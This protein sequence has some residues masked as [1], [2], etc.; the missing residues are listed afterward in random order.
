MYHYKGCTS[1][2]PWLFSQQ[3]IK[4]TCF[5]SLHVQLVPCYTPVRLEHSLA[6]SG[7]TNRLPGSTILSWA[8]EYPMLGPSRDFNTKRGDFKILVLFVVICCW[9]R[10]FLENQGSIVACKTHENQP[11]AIKKSAGSLNLTQI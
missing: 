11:F 7:G 6:P 9:N 1:I 8:L 5:D 10:L 2:Y 4:K 3:I